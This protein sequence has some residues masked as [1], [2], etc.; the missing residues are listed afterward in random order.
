M[1][2]YRTTYVTTKA[3]D[4][5]Q[6]CTLSQDRQSMICDTALSHVI[7]KAM[8]EMWYCT[9]DCQRTT[10]GIVH[11]VFKGQ[12]VLYTWLSKDKCGIVPMTVNSKA[13]MWYCTH[14]C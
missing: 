8:H 4:K 11:M 13:K 12:N 6:Y 3:K 2:L 7:N 5:I 14:D 10:C 9:Y 1:V